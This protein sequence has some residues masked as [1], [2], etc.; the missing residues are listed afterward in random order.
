MKRFTEESTRRTKPSL[1]DTCKAKEDMDPLYRSLSTPQG[2]R[3][4]GKAGTAKE[5]TASS[6]G[7]N[8]KKKG[9]KKSVVQRTEPRE[10]LNS[11]NSQHALA[12]NHQIGETNLFEQRP[13]YSFQCVCQSK[14]PESKA[15]LECSRCHSIQHDG[16]MG[17]NAELNPYECPSCLL[18]KLD[19][20]LQCKRVVVGPNII[21]TLN[22][23]LNGIIN[24]DVYEKSFALTQQQLDSNS[25][26]IRCIRLDGKDLGHYWP[27]HSRLYING[28][29]VE[30]FRPPKDQ[31]PR[32]RKDSPKLIRA[33]HCVAGT[34]QIL[35]VKVNSSKDL[36]EK[37][38][39][40]VNI[41]KTCPYV[42]SIVETVRFTEELLVEKVRRES[43]PSLEES[44]RTFMKK[45]RAQ[46]RIGSS[47]DCICEAALIQVPCTDPYLPE[48]MMQTPVYGKRCKH[49]QSF[50]LER[51]VRMNGRMSLWKCP[52]CFEKAFELEVDTYY[53]ALLVSIKSLNIRSPEISVDRHGTF[54]INNYTAVF[55]NHKFTITKTDSGS[56]GE[57]R[58]E[59][60]GKKESLRRRRGTLL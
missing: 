10:R 19:P 24:R 36:T 8:S 16:C 41:D 20:L 38:A 37:Q 11:K 48:T 51:F 53:E 59:A 47:E 14:L 12:R 9:A 28:K 40:L 32:K 60:K 29:L 26:Y 43:R 50:D 39:R 56:E 17:L 57:C 31:A 52:Y 6:A 46:Y 1:N 4:A 58:E 35:L 55:D 5:L 13:N 21:S 54:T 27:L 7:I 18:S 2:F 44:R 23:N 33:E 49:L 34:N 3:A 30:T 45:L 42:F 15:L 22:E 25:L